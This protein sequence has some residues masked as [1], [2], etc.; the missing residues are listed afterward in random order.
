M[1]DKQDNL[2]K[3]KHKSALPKRKQ[4]FYLK[5]QQWNNFDNNKN[6]WCCINHGS[7]NC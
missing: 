3:N 2:Q 6:R 5:K 1:N 4:Y 7:S